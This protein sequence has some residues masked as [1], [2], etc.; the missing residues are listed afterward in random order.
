MKHIMQWCARPFD[1]FGLIKCPSTSS[2]TLAQA[3]LSTIV[4]VSHSSMLSSLHSPIEMQC[5]IG[6]FL[7]RRDG[8]FSQTASLSWHCL[9]PVGEV[10]FRRYC[11]AACCMAARLHS[12]MAAWLHDSRGRGCIMQPACRALLGA[13]WRGA[14]SEGR[15]RSSSWRGRSAS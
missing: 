14:F 9:G 11:T 12:C 15:V 8:T 5:A 2:R 13:C 4:S 3:F 6:V 10:R 1:G 7:Q